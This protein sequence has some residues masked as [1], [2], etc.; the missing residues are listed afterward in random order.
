MRAVSSA[1]SVA[2]HVGLG[3]LVLAGTTNRVRSMPA[4]ARDIEFVVS[5]SPSRSAPAHGAQG[6]PLPL[7]APP[8]AGPL[9]A[10]APV[11]EGVPSLAPQF[12]GFVP[13][14]A[15]PSQVA[16]AWAEAI[17]EAGPQVLTGPLPAYPELLRQAGVQGRVVLEAV[18]DTSGR[19]VP[20]SVAVI[21][22]TNPAF[23]A[24]ARQALL[25][26]LFR[27]ALVRGRLVALRVQIPYEFTIRSSHFFGTSP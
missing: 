25:A 5:A 26:T 27:P 17:G 4:S 20:A 22:A 21:S 7:P 2:A 13:S 10:A 9:S 23:V 18:V 24:P 15:A 14:A 3:V 16:G 1:V 19:V 11:I 12:S 6:L 8:D